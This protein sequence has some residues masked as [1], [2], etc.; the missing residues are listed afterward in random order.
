[1]KFLK[2]LLIVLLILAIVLPLKWLITA[3]CLDMKFVDYMKDVVWVA[4][5]NIWEVI[6]SLYRLPGA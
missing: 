2:G 3:N 6:K 1:M 4:L 5:K